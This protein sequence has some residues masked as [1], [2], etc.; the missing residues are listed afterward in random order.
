MIEGGE[1]RNGARVSARSSLCRH[2]AGRMWD[3]IANG[4]GLGDGF[5]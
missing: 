4:R 3:V 1:S 5:L 2:S